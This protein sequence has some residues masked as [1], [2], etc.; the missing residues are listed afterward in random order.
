M[1]IVNQNPPPVSWVRVSFLFYAPITALGLVAIFM[2]GGPSLLLERTLGEAPDRGLWIGSLA[3]L[4]IVFGLR[5][6]GMVW[7][8]SRRLE[9][10]FIRMLGPLSWPACFFLALASSLGEE[11]VFRAV[12]Q[13]W[14]GWVATSLIFGL[15]HFPFDRSLLLWTPF[16]I[17]M[18]FLLGWL[19]D[20]TGTLVTPLATHFVINF[21]NLLRISRLAALRQR[22]ETELGRARP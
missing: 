9:Q 17:A 4:A 8:P 5:F 20:R 1:P 18:G 19:Y 10:S 7:G 6:L 11:V 16:A 12:L 14:L 21:L 15:L 22:S 13:P 2:Q 3:G